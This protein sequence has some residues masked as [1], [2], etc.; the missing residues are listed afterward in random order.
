MRIK[1]INTTKGEIQSYNDSNAEWVVK[2]CGDCQ[3]FDMRKFTQKR[4]IELFSEL[5]GF[6]VAK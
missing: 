1:K 6:E 3:R 2:G 4:S 5:N